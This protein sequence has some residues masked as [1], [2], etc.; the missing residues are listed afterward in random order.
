MHRR[1]NKAHHDRAAEPSLPSYMPTPGPS[2]RHH[3]SQ[4]KPTPRRPLVYLADRET[5]TQDYPLPRLPGQVGF[6][7]GRPQD[8]LVPVPPPP[9]QFDNHDGTDPVYDYDPQFQPSLNDPVDPAKSR[10]RRKRVAQWRRW[11]IEVIPAL[12]GPYINLLAATNSLRDNPPPPS[13]KASLELVEIRACKCT[14]AAGQLLELGYFP[15][16]PCHPTL[17]VDVRMLLFVT[18]LFVRVSPNTTAWCATVEDFLQGLGYRLTS[19]GSLRRRFGIALMWFNS[20]QDA[21]TSHVAKVQLCV[22]KLI[23]NLDDGIQQPA[24]PEPPSPSQRATVEEVEDEASEPPSPRQWATIEEVEDEGLSDTTPL[25][26]SRKRPRPLSEVPF[27]EPPPSDTSKKKSY[28]LKGP[29][30][31]IC[32]DACFTQKHNQQVRDPPRHH[33]RTVFIEEADVQR[34]E[35]Y[36]DSVRP[37]RPHN[38]K[39]KPNPSTDESTLE[40]DGYEGPL[41]VPTSVLDGCERSFLAADEQREKA[42]TQFFASTTLMAMLCHHDRVLWVVDMQSAGEKQHYVLILLEILF[43]HLPPQFLIG[44]LYDIGCQTHRSCIKWDFLKLYHHWMIFGISV[45]HAFGH[46][47]PCQII[48]HPRKRKGFGFSDGEGCERFWHSISKLIGYLRV[49]GHHQRLYTLDLQIQHA[50][51][52]NLEKLG[53]WLLRRTRHCFEKRK[54]AE[55]ALA[56][57]GVPLDILQSE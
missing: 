11:D 42:S 25:Q 52:E 13:R 45:F 17:A 53:V 23:T 39:K 5:L 35:N 43:Q 1:M 10:H 33:S 3:L 49:C 36:V 31:I 32:V 41:R 28:D 6:A 4:S 37:S 22:R 57:C 24:P 55:E 54:A 30:A 20:L 18:K 40:E 21:M 7:G 50:G 51:L 2:Q 26:A 56:A 8:G 47:W 44:L 14:P 27:P 15:C 38:K 29:D 12:I 46:Q 19:A 16:A 9:P 48:Y 34:M